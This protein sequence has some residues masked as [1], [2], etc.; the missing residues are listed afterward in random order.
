MKK[1]IFLFFAAILCAIGMNAATE[2]YIYVGISNNFEQYK[3]DTFGFN[4]WGGTSGGVKSGTKIAEYNWDGRN[5]HMYRVQVYD[6]NNKAQFK[7]N[8][9]WWVP[10]NGKDVTLNGTKN[11]AV[12]FSHNNDGWDGQF[13]QN[14]Q[15]TS[16]VSLEVSNSSVS[17]GEDVT[18]T[19]S[20][21]SN[22]TY[23]DIKS[24]TYKISPISGASINGNTFTATTA[25]VYTVTATVTYNPKYFTEITSTATATT[26]ITVT[27]AEEPKHNV[28]VFYKYNKTEI[29]TATTSNVGESTPSSIIAPKV[30]GYKFVD[31]TLGDGVQ[32]ADA[33]TSET[34]SITTKNSG[35]YTL[36]ANY[37]KLDIVYFVNNKKWSK[38][39]VYAW[40]ADENKN[41]D[42]PGVT[43]EKLGKTIENFDVY[44]YSTDPGKFENIIFN[45]G[46]GNQTENYTWVDGNYYYMAADAPTSGGTENEITTMLKLASNV[47]LAG[48]MNEWKS[49][50]DELK[51]ATPDATIA[52][53]TKYL[54]ANK[55]YEFKI[56]REGTWTSR[57]D[58][59]DD[60][61]IT[62]TIEGVQ[63]SSKN[64]KNCKMRTTIAGNYT[65]TW[66]LS[67]SKL[68]ITYPI[69]EVIIT[70]TYTI[71]GAEALT[72]SY[73]NPADSNNDM[74]D[75][76]GDGI[77]TLI[78]ENVTL[79][80]NTSYEYKVARDHVW[81]SG[82]YPASGQ[83]NESLS[84]AEDGLYKVVFTYDPTQQ[85]LNAT[86]TKTGEATITH[87]VTLVG[88][89]NS[90]T[91]EEF[92]VSGT[93]ATLEKSLNAGVYEFKIVEDGNYC[94]N[95]GIMT[96]PNSKDW[97]FDSGN[98]AKIF[99]DIAGTYTFTWNLENDKLSVTHPNL[100][101]NYP[102]IAI[103]GTM[104]EWKDDANVSSSVAEGKT[105]IDVTLEE[106]KTYEFKV[107]VG[108]T[109]LGN[110]GTMDKGN[111]SDWTFNPNDGN[112]KITTYAAG[113]YTF[114]W[115]HATQKLSVTY[116]TGELTTLPKIYLAGAMLGNDVW[117]AGKQ[118]FTVA[119]D[120]KTATYTYNF[121]ERD[122]TYE[123][124]IIS[125]DAWMGNN[126]KMKRGNSEG[127]TFNSNDGNASIYMDIPGNYIFTWEY[128]TNKLTVTYPELPK[129][130]L[131][132]TMCNGT[133]DAQ[134]LESN[135]ILL[136]TMDDQAHAYAK[137]NLAANK[138]RFKMVEIVEGDKWLGYKEADQTMTETNNANWQFAE[139][140][141]DVFI[142]IKTAGNYY[143]VWNYAAQKLTVT[144]PVTIDED[145]A[146]N[147]K[148]SGYNGKIADVIV[149]RAFVNTYWQTI[150]L[151]FS[152]NAVQINAMF[153]ANTQVAKLAS[154][155][156]QSKNNDDFVLN[157]DFVN[158]IEAGTPYLIKPANN[159]DEGAKVEG[160]VINTNTTNITTDDA[161]MIAVLDKKTNTNAKDYW[162]AENGYLYP[163][164]NTEIKALRAYFY[165]PN[166]STASP[167]R[168]RVAFN[169]NVETEV[170]NITAP[171]IKAIKV[172]Q[173]G[174]LI[175]IRDGVKY[176]VQGQKL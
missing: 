133:G 118:E 159:V 149:N 95:D 61:T 141:N 83:P 47:Y 52:I 21:S 147:S 49:N 139:H 151:P 164:N 119:A 111:C 157:F 6:D 74:T 77:Y 9:S 29:K 85:K 64:E 107:R 166:I 56:V 104:N 53:I 70:Y 148:Y 60:K 163:F 3:G 8:D 116:P 84:V 161:W 113:T 103:K 142:E 156:V 91:A 136:Q 79:A 109:D 54:D 67:T 153:G 94:G 176:N 90:W 112:A 174:Q 106:Q 110:G 87:T 68:S 58:Q 16:T 42:W 4:F 76:D 5:Y 121:T 7:G 127:W 55:D 101:G 129:V 145:A 108:A 92:T 138:Y 1:S 2:R 24:V 44:Y 154:S 167:V 100:E 39:N 120:K 152:M 34:I 15:E 17:I 96:R 140:G 71:A 22:S 23:N 158:T 81:D 20:L 89:M 105:S 137:V 82:Q 72:G 35:N 88:T 40:D 117:E 150:T 36:T 18:L 27:S 38:V 59:D 25:G 65:F 135:Q 97:T 146:D 173:N 130:A 143:F 86:A 66:E 171:E 160:V 32:T 57:Q 115:E 132:G 33:L 75:D 172:I 12:F 80:A 51:K 37:D 73:W 78:K 50:V 144:Y 175:I 26:T 14:Y 168:A 102:T 124:K 169:E 134:W 128:A 170:E 131:R 19:A 69:E 10:G 28:T 48:S 45:D 30:I 63:F 31:W 62:E 43:I 114:V 93:T 13:Q 99:A 126:G 46:N 125:N 165:F 98:N 41:G 162:L 122:K 123:F 11:N 155:E